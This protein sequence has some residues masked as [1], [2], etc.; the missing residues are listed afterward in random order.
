[1]TTLARRTDPDTSHDAVPTTEDRRTR[2]QRILRAFSLAGRMTPYE[3]MVMTQLTTGG[4]KRVSDL[5]VNGYLR[6]TGERRESAGCTTHKL[7]EVLE[8]TEKGERAARGLEE[9]VFATPERVES[10]AILLERAKAAEMFARELAD[11]LEK[12]TPGHPLITAWDEYDN[13]GR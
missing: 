9:I 6:F 13:S 10:R 2:G 7:H 12:V 5:K 1:M 4:W 3:A 11:E 8:L